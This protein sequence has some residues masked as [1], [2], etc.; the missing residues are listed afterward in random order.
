M[1]FTISQ[2]AEEFG[3]T[4]RTIRYYEELQLLKPK[5]DSNKR[6]MYSNKEYTTLKLIVRGKKLGFSLEEIKEM[7]Q[8]F[9]KDPSGKKQLEKVIELGDR[10]IEEV[11]EKIK[12]LILIK[13]ELERIHGDLVKR[14]DSLRS[15]VE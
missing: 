7:I 6:R 2:L 1:K 14:L 10:R 3:C 15:D 12:D 5:R 13:K 9:D 4:T 11:N 8:L